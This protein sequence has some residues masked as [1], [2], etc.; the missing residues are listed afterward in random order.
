M[1]L[2]HFF[3]CLPAFVRVGPILFIRVRNTYCITLLHP[4]QIR[5]S[6]QYINWRHS[7][8]NYVLNGIEMAYYANTVTQPRSLRNN[9]P[10]LRGRAII[11]RFCVLADKVTLHRRKVGWSIPTVLSRGQRFPEM[12]FNGGRDTKHWRWFHLGAQTRDITLPALISLPTASARHYIQSTNFLPHQMEGPEMNRV[13]GEW[14]G[15]CD[16]GCVT[17]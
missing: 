17:M 4:I 5:V 16:A 6:K 14:G 8:Y 1:Q 15:P 10:T 11:Q 3:L 13:R 7:K 2:K 12:I 9:L